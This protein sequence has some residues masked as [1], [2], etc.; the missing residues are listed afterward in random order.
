[1]PDPEFELVSDTGSEDQT[2]STDPTPS[3]DDQNNS[4]AE[5]DPTP[6]ADPTETNPTPDPVDPE[7]VLYELPD[8]RK[9]DAETLSKEWKENFY[10]E[11]TRKSQELAGYKRGEQE[12]TKKPEAKPAEDPE[13]WKNPDYVPQTYGEIVEI[14]TKEAMRR[15]QSQAQEEANRTRA[16]EEAVSNELS[17]IKK[18]DPKLDENALFAHANKYGFNNLKMAYQNMSEL[19][20]VEADTEQRVLK[21]L[22]TREAAPV[23]GRPGAPVP[24]P[25][26]EIEYGGFG[27]SALDAYRRI[28]GKK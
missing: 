18:L 4:G 3:N 27:E 22:K 19:R 20:R 7:P 16:I 11:Y 12:F 23:S 25:S 10:P 6:A 28:S 17:E 9:V 1:M 2:P 15:I 13:P 24:T 21:N 8:G 5:A 26:D 14:A